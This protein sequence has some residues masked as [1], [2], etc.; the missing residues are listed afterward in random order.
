MLKLL[1]AYLNRLFKWHIF[2]ILMAVMLALGVALGFIFRELLIVYQ[3]PVIAS[4]LIF[5][6]YI[7]VIIALFNYPFFTNGTIRNQITVGHKRSSIFFADWVASNV[8]AVIL[9]LILTL[10]VLGTAAITGDSSLVNWENIV[11]GIIVSSLLVML[12]ATISQLICVML[13]GAMSFLVNYLGN[14]I[15]LVA[16]MGAMAIEG[17]PKALLYFIPSVICMNLNYFNDASVPNPMFDA[18]E[19]MS[20]ASSISAMTFDILPAVGAV[21]LEI[22]VV[23]L[24]GNLYFKKTDIK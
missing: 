22:A 14:Q 9:Y 6:I 4:S 17:I 8:F 2:R 19:G 3:I 23:Y 21:I 13:K 11:F 24:I 15:I 18:S 1:N 12:F 16:A 20:V 7:G 5:P 10:G